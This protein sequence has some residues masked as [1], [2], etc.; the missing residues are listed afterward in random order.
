MSII[1]TESLNPELLGV[2]CD[3]CHAQLLDPVELGEVLHIRLHAGYG[4]EWGDGNIV[5]LD[6]CDAC[7]HGLL[8]PHARVTP[9]S[10][11]LRGHFGVGLAR[12]YR[13]PSRTPQALA[14]MLAPL[15][16]LGLR[17]TWAWLQYR[18]GR[19]LIPLLLCLRP[20][21]TAYSGIRQRWAFEEWALRAAY[22]ERLGD[23]H[24]PN[25]TANPDDPDP[26]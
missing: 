8:S 10:E 17:G 6:L 21:R 13:M 25:Q 16:S 9:S 2:I 24:V 14:G 12:R 26:H 20:L 11:E 22:W 7:A 5:E 4:S 15:P 3:R 19:A 18:T 1:H 23:A